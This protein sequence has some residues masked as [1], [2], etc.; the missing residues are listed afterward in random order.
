MEGPSVLSF[1]GFGDKSREGFTTS[2][3]TWVC[4]ITTGERYENNASSTAVKDRTGAR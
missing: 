2:K 1:E 4:S 3:D